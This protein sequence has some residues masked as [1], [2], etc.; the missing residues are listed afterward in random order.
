MCKEVAIKSY[1]RLDRNL[2]PPN[3]CPDHE[4]MAIFGKHQY[5]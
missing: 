4:A 2:L 1:R 3:L 5:F